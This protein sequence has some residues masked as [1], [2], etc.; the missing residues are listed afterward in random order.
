MWLTGHSDDNVTEVVPRENYADI[1]LLLT[2][3]K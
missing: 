1:L 2:L 3:K